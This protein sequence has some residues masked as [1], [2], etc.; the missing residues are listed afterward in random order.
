MQIDI[1]ALQVHVHECMYMKRSSDLL[2]G[3][4]DVLQV[5]DEGRLALMQR[6]L[7]LFKR[8]GD[9]CHCLVFPFIELSRD[10]AHQLDGCS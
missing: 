8:A 10:L 5:C 9:F 1:Q 2:L 3:A 7:Q 4:A 6:L